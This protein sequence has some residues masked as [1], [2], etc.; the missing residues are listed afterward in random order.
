MR[1]LTTLAGGLLG[2]AEKTHIFNFFRAKI[3]LQIAKLLDGYSVNLSLF[4][5]K[6]LVRPRRLEI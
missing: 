1:T 5:N 2:A 3:D 6:L 4:V